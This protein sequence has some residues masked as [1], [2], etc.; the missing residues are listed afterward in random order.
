MIN[1]TKEFG[2][3]KTKRYHTDQIIGILTEADA[4]MHIN[5]LCGKHGINDA[6]IYSWK[7]EYGGMAIIDG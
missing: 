2:R 1:S 4:G 6:T 7:T 5:E 3:M